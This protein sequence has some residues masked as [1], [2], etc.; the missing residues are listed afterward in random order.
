MEFETG[1]SFVCFILC[2]FY[3]SHFNIVKG[4][5]RSFGSKSTKYLYRKL[6]FNLHSKT[7]FFIASSKGIVSISKISLKK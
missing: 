2:P 5:I 7:R 4:K 6:K 3:L 1:I